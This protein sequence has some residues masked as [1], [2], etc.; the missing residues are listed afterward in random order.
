MPNRFD[1]NGILYIDKNTQL[2]KIAYRRPNIEESLDD[3]FFTITAAVEYR[4]DKISMAFYGTPDYAWAIHLAN[5]MFH[6]RDFIAGVT[7]R[8]PATSSFI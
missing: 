5:K 1:K 3:K 2:K 7:I 6:I 8:I 4:P